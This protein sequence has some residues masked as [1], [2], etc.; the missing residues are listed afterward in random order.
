MKS[1]LVMSMLLAIVGLSLIVEGTRAYFADTTAVE[2]F[3]ANGTLNLGV[4]KETLFQIENLVPGDTVESNIELSNDGNIDMEKVLLY[5]N[6][7]VIDNGDPNNGDDL[8]NH[9]QVSFIHDDNEKEN[10][11]FQKTLSELN[12]NPAEILQAFPSGSASESITVQ[13]TFVDNG[14]NQNHFQSDKLQIEWEFEAMQRDGE[15]F[16]LT[17]TTAVFQDRISTRSNFIFGA[18]QGEELDETGEQIENEQTKNNEEE[19]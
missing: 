19:G 8:G 18:W 2:S 13:F 4:S 12:K 3:V 11:L 6:Y 1:K 15:T 7:K 5:S 14:E 17:S 16:S 9:I 10:L